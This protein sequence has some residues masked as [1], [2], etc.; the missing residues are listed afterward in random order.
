MC[1]ISPGPDLITSSTINDDKFHLQKSFRDFDP[2]IKSYGQI[3]ER[4]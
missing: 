3:S 4:D 2:P 1:Q